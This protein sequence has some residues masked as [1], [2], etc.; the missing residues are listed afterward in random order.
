VGNAG[1]LYTPNNSVNLMETI[2]EMLTNQEIYKNCKENALQLSRER[3]NDKITA[4]K[5]LK[6]YY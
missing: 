2:R 1:L 5:L 3:Y 6:N 4:E